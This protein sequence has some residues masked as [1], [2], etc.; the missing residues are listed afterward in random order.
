MLLPEFF[1]PSRPSVGITFRQPNI[2]DA[3]R[4]NKIPEQ[5]EERQTTAYLN[6]LQEPAGQSDA[7]RW[8]AQDRRTALWWIYTGSHDTPVETFTYKCRNCNED[9]YHDCD[10]NDLAGEINVLEREPVIEDVTI[11]AED[12]PHQW[13]LMPLDGWAMEMLEMRRCSLPDEADPS[14]ADALIDL[15]LW[16]FVYQCELYYD[17]EGS[18]DEQADRRFDIVSSMAIDTEFMVLASKVRM[19]QEELE[20]GLPCNIDKGV[21]LLHLP[22]HFCTAPLKDKEATVGYSTRLW[23]PFRSVYFIPQMGLERLSQLSLQPG[24]VWGYSSGRCGRTD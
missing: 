13:R 23:V 2:R 16:E 15:R 5:E 24:F 1:L 19:M 20:H 11:N 4:F 7:R 14:Y 18:R 6:S 10:M 12:K 8:T 17:V 21:T 3:M 9:H 22:P